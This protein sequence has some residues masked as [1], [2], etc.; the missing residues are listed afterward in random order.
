MN[1]FG[2]R[3]E[4]VMSGSDDG[5]IFIWNKKTAKLVQLLKGDSFVVNCLQVYRVMREIEVIGPSI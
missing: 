5:Y 2:P 3:S 1:F 4:F